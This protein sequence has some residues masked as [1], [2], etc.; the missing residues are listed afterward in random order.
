MESSGIIFHK[1]VSNIQDSQIIKHISRFQKGHGIF[2][3]SMSSVI[4][5]NRPQNQHN[6]MA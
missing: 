6:V 1:K 2:E 4:S 3:I 5:A